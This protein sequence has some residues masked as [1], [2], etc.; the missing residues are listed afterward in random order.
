MGGGK[1]RKK[2]TFLSLSLSLNSFK[3]QKQK[4]V[5]LRP[6]ERARRLPATGNRGDRRRDRGAVLDPPAR[7]YVGR[8]RLGDQGLG[9]GE[10]SGVFDDAE[11]GV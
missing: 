1:A 5:G 7:E 8:R 2:L 9:R 11:L 6:G 3:P 10:R 4:I